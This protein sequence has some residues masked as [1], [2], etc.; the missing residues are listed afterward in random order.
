M[1]TSVLLVY[2]QLDMGIQKMLKVGDKITEPQAAYLLL[3]R[4][5]RI[6]AKSRKAIEKV[7]QTQ[8]DALVSFAYNVGINALGG[9]TLLKKHNAR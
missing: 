5:G 9:S 3:Q 8:F 1:P 2:G 6:L 7:S 4:V